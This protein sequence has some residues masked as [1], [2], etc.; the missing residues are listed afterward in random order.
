MFNYYGKY[1]AD[2][3]KETKEFTYIDYLLAMDGPD[4]M[5]IKWDTE[6]GTGY[7]VVPVRYCNGFSWKVTKT[8]VSCESVQ[9]M[10]RLFNNFKNFADRTFAHFA[11]LK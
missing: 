10:F 2:Y 7:K 4:K 1:V 8:G 11:G 6:N 9:N 5:V 3:N